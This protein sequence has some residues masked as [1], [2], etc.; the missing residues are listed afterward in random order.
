VFPHCQQPRRIRLLCAACLV[1]GIGLDWRL[2]RDWFA[3]ALTDHDFAINECMWQN[4]GLVGVD[5]F[6]RGLQW[7]VV[8][9]GA[10]DEYV[11]SELV[12]ACQMRKGEPFEEEASSYTASNR[13]TRRWLGLPPL[14]L[15]PWP[16]ALHAAVARRRPPVEQVQAVA[17]ARRQHLTRAYQ[18]GGRVSRVGVRIELASAEAASTELASPEATISRSGAGSRAPES[19][20]SPDEVADAIETPRSS[21]ADA[22][23]GCV[24][25]ASPADA[26]GCIP[27]GAPELCARVPEASLTLLDSVGS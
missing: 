2:G 20:R 27:P 25:L 13:Y 15:P 16:P 17:T 7:E 11:G 6:Y 23:A 19:S 24:P 1:E 5:P 4:A 12:E 21:R 14:A 3:Y 26:A 18:L 8:P 22:S 10:N 9:D